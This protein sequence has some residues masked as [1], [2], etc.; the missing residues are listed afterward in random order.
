MQLNAVKNPASF[1]RMILVRFIVSQSFSFSVPPPPPLVRPSGEF[2]DLSQPQ[3]NMT[4]LPRKL[5]CLAYICLHCA[6]P[7]VF[8]HQIPSLF[9]RQNDLCIGNGRKRVSP[10]FTMSVRRGHTVPLSLL[11]AIKLTR[12][13]F[14][15][16]R[17][18]V[19]DHQ[20][21]EITQA[22]VRVLSLEPISL[23]GTL[24]ITYHY[25]D[26]LHHSS[27][28]SEGDTVIIKIM[29]LRTKHQ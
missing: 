10:G 26:A 1:C 22:K 20:R 24:K 18:H 3:H 23:F 28:S 27:R 25:R 11:P 2:E 17:Q 29:T 13:F 8:S 14:N 6:P 4:S 21:R 9:R 16:S 15:W 19:H 5:L 12:H 7:F